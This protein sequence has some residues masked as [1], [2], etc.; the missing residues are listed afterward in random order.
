MAATDRLLKLIAA[1]NPTADV[2]RIQ[3]AYDF[4]AQAHGAEVRLS[5]EPYI[6][7]PLAVAEKLAEIRLDED[8]I[9]AA[10]LHDVRED[11]DIQLKEIEDR[12]GKDVAFLVE[13]V[14]KLGKLKYR[15]LTRYVE[16]LRKMFIAMAQ[17]IRVII[18]KFA[19]RIHNLETLQYL[20]K[21]KQLRTARESLEIY[22]PIANRLGMGAIK[23]ELEDLAFAYVFP[24][25]HRRITALLKER[26]PRLEAALEKSQKSLERELAKEHIPLQSIHGRRKHS[27]SLYKKLLRPAYDQDINRIYDLIALRIV[28][29]NME[30]C[31]RTLGIVHHLWKPITGRFKDYI[32]QP[33][34]NGYR[35]LHTTVFADN[36]EPLEIQIRDKEMHA[37]AEYGI[38]AHWHYDEQGKPKRGNVKDQKFEWVDNLAKW[39]EEFKNDK[40]YLDALKFNVFQNQFFV[41]TPRGDVIELPEDSTP[42]DFAYRI[43]S[44]I[45]DTYGGARVNDQFVSYETKLKSGD[46]VEIVRDKRRKHPSRDWLDVVKTPQ[47]REHIRR[48]LRRAAGTEEQI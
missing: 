42:I 39:K 17:D 26:T 47:A 44:D 40:E 5:G 43:H 7:H 41:F 2:P 34:P 19:D 37:L 18:I 6:T 28:V 24:K 25:E 38:A 9:V 13:G 46:V 8:T 32:A 12:F 48:G 22:A 10:L 29:N 31:Y 35:S 21:K 11:T 30:D 27:Y 45:G 14:T 3:R 1:Y 23:G 20:P 33:K 16:S 15:G 4:A 36:N